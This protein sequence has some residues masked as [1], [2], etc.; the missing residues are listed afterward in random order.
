MKLSKNIVIN[1]HAYTQYRQHLWKKWLA[2]FMLIVLTLILLFSLSFH[3][4]LAAQQADQRTLSFSEQRALFKKLVNVTTLSIGFFLLILLA[5][6][7]I[8]YLHQ[9]GFKEIIKI[10]TIDL[11]KGEAEENRCG[12]AFIT[13]SV[14]NLVSIKNLQGSLHFLKPFYASP[15]HLFF[16]SPQEKI[17]ELISLQPQTISFSLVCHSREGIPIAI[18]TI[19]IQYRF[20]ADSSPFE[21]VRASDFSSEEKDS[22]QNY[23][24][25][26]GNLNEQEIVQLIST[27][28]IEKSMCRISIE[29]WQENTFAFAIP[30]SEEEIRQHFEAI[31]QYKINTTSKHWRNKRILPAQASYARPLKRECF[32]YRSHPKGCHLSQKSVYAFSRPNQT[33]VRKMNKEFPQLE[34]EL[35]EEVKN[36]LKTFHFHLIS[37]Q[38]PQSISFDEVITQKIRQTLQEENAL[39]LNLANTDRR[40]REIIRENT[41]AHL[42]NLQNKVQ[43][44]QPPQSSTTPP[45][46]VAQTAQEKIFRL[47]SETSDKRKDAPSSEGH[48]G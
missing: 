28:A 12:P 29:T 45:Q 6:L 22:M 37:L 16:L 31:R 36:A 25:Q 32:S 1:W 18:P 5:Y 42:Q 46:D 14:T 19:R 44:S 39:I 38:I 35:Q 23:L 48:K 9:H 3:S 30:F 26:K 10:P 33:S 41:M 17:D 47:A 8:R 7:A 43:E 34:S 13:L 40:A 20:L 15:K 4:V 2:R 21:K 11:R 24:L 27:Q